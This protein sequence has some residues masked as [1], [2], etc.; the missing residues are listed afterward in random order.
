MLVANLFNERPLKPLF[1]RGGPPSMQKCWYELGQLDNFGP[2]AEAT[3][4]SG[5]RSKQQGTGVS[6][7]QVKAATV[8]ALK[9]S[10]SKQVIRIH[11]AIAQQ[12][13]ERAQ[14]NTLS[15][16]AHII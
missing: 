15:P 3:G 9:D 8:H 7:N 2:H 12:R 14:A 6:G 5:N 1:S 4:V 10:V 11:N 13:L 16:V